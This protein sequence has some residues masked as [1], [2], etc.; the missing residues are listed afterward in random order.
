MESS[1]PSGAAGLIER[2]GRGRILQTADH[3]IS[4]L[5]QLAEPPG[6]WGVSELSR[7]LGLAR[8]VTHSLLQTLVARGIAAQNPQS[9]RYYL[10][11]ALVPLADAAA[12]RFDLRA[13]ARAA[14]RELAAESDECAYLIVPAG[15]MCVV[16]DRA[17]PSQVMRVTMEVGSRGHLHAG[18]NPKA[19]LAFLPDEQIERVLAA[20]GLPKRAPRTTT[21][22]A[23]LRRE[24]EEI[25]ARGYSFTEQEMFEG[26]AGV[27]APVFD[28]TGAVVASIG[29]GGL[30]GRVRAQK[31]R[32]IEL[33]L[34]AARDVSA[35]LGYSGREGVLD[36]ATGRTAHKPR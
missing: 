36:W 23:R 13:E 16:L 6:E 5:M 3:A 22:A 35:R 7:A 30:L 9:R 28:R 12:R 26:I 19:I 34:R 27:A 17:D 11:L 18:S 20:R 1:G 15:D 29:I 24:L 32:H 31:E 25:R 14:L 8:S 21:E 4:V 2:R 10:G 33:T